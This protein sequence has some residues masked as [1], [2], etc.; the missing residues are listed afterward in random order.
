LRDDAP[1]TLSEKEETK[2]HFT[3]ETNAAKFISVSSLECEC[4]LTDASG[5]MNY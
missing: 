2:T 3:V 5:E 1:G 4:S